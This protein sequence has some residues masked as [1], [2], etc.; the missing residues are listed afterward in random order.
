M[1]C[2][3]GVLVWTLIHPK[4]GNKL[5]Y[6]YLWWWVLLHDYQLCLIINNSFGSLV[7]NLNQHPNS[8]GCVIGIM[9]SN[10]SKIETRTKTWLLLSI[11][12]KSKL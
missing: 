1:W 9:V 8:N 6:P 2:I 5:C 12:P 3:G 7:P 4:G 10:F 11:V